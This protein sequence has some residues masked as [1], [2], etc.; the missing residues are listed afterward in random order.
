MQLKLLLLSFLFLLTPP[1]LH[2][3]NFLEKKAVSIGNPVGDFELTDIVGKSFRLSDYRGKVVMI[4][5]WSA[6]CPFVKRYEERLQKIT[7]D[8]SNRDVAVFA[9]DSNVTETTEQIS[10]VAA[11]RGVNYP[12][13]IDPQS[14]IAD[15]FGAI[16][17]PHVFVIDRE[18]KMAYE[19][20]VDD[21]G[22]G[23]DDPV[24]KNYTR[25]ALDAVIA[26]T[27]V[28]ASTTKTVGCT[29]KRE[30]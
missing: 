14:K 1:I 10:K 11:E 25:E 24:N 8:Y 6:T 16:T 28:T 2:A 15:R 13:L 20:A 4:H 18:G 3:E 22:W 19:G 26:G 30:Q 7:S 23:E 5:F 27:P 17:T 21:Q 9:L 29:I 12:I